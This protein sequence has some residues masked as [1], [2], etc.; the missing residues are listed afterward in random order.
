MPARPSALLGKT[1][2]TKRIQEV[3]KGLSKVSFRF[4]RRARTRGLSNTKQEESK[5]IPEWRRS[6]NGGGKP[7][8]LILSI[9]FSIGVRIL[10]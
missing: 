6:R 5:V 8:N 7:Y 9:L 10:D 2:Q 4:E 3:V 1:T